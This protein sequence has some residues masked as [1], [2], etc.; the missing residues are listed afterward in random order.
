MDT[1]LDAVRQVL[2]EPEFYT[3]LGSSTNYSWDY[4]LMLEYLISGIILCVGV[5]WIFRIVSKL[6]G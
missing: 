4:G 6:F 2:G 3:R 5:S 1:V